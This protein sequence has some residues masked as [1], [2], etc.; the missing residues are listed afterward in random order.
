MLSAIE[1]PFLGS[2]KFAQ[3]NYGTPAI[4]KNRRYFDYSVISAND[5]DPFGSY[6]ISPGASDVL[7]FATINCIFKWT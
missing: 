6:A 2:R 1:V 4:N 5:A 3:S 7:D